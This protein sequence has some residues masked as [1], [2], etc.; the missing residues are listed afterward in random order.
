[1]M[2]KRVTTAC[3]RTTLM[4]LMAR[5]RRA[6]TLAR[7]RG[8]GPGRCT[9]ITAPRTGEPLS[10]ARIAG[11]VLR[12][13]RHPILGDG[14]PQRGSA[15]SR[16]LNIWAKRQPPGRFP[17]PESPPALTP[18]ADG[19][20]NPTASLPST[21]NPA[22]AAAAIARAETSRSTIVS[23]QQESPHEGTLPQRHTNCEGCRHRTRP[24]R[25]PGPQLDATMHGRI[26]DR[27]GGGGL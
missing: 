8:H 17:L 13:Q 1:M 20:I 5:Y 24:F 16:P 26:R 11:A 22:S 14:G 25:C 23:P 18:A 4:D 21:V 15:E 6:A 9:P 7:R 2:A 10:I 12:P 3:R 19:T 27:V